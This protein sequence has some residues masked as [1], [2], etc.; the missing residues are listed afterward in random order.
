M[1]VEVVLRKFLQSLRNTVLVSPML[2]F[3]LLG[4][5]ALA[6]LST[7][8]HLAD[9]AFWPTQSNSSRDIFVGPETCARCHGSMA[10]SQQATPMARNM[11][12]ASDS[13]ILHSHP[14][15]SFAVAGY[16]Y[17]MQSAAGQTKY[18]VTDGT[19]TLSYPLTWAFGTGRVGQSY[20]FKKDDGRFYEA[21]VTYF[22]SLKDL[23][24]TPDRELLT[25][26]NIDEAMYRQVP[27]AE[28]IRCFNCHTTASTIGGSFDE[29]HF[30]PGVTC[31][32]CHGPGAAHVKA[33]DDLTAGKAGSKVDVAKAAIFNSAHL[34]PNDAVDFCGACHTT[35]WD[36]K[37]SGM[38]GVRT[39]R[40][41]PARLVSSKCWG[42]GDSRLVCT[43]CHDPHQQ[44]QTN[45]ADYDHTCLSCHVNSLGAPKTAALPGAACPVARKNC[46]SCHMEKTYVPN[47]H[48]Y[49]TDHRIRIVK[50]GEAFPN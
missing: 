28:V 33:M 21:R 25:P 2:W 6:Q 39:V 23:G 48:D 11:M 44:L 5:V 47:M 10:Q 13:G 3:A 29:K 32:A 26:A 15:M 4:H 18:S 37:L 1:A 16:Q 41:A 17:K 30:I 46:T 27:Q 45:A 9:S 34:S 50:A 43:N 20:L 42:K 49:F 35:W 19:N 38:T 12:T 31:E 40:S 36:V 22:E 24:F 8:D 14:D 7:D